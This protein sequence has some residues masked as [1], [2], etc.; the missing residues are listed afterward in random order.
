M[1]E[2]KNFDHLIGTEGFS[3]DLMKNHFTLYQGYVKNTNL[4]GEELM[5]LAKEGKLAS[6]LY[7][8]LKRRITWEYNGMHLHELYFSN[9][10]KGGIAIEED[11]ALKKEIIVQYGSWEAWQAQFKATGSIRGI[12]WAILYR[13]PINGMLVNT[14]VNEHADGHLAGGTPIIIMDVFEHAFMLDYGLK[15]ADYIE[16]F[17]KAIDW[18]VAN[19]RFVQ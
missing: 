6:P 8:E 12:G 9:M 18:S 4:L 15:R 19:N 2:A 17:F 11:S 5:G 7:A 13:D 10:K 14:W 16:T 3:D 1:F